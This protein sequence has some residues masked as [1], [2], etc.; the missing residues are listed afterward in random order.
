MISVEKEFKNIMTRLSVSLLFF[1]ILF[2]LLTGGASALGELLISLFPRS[3]A[4]YIVSDLASSLAYLIS[5][6]L[7][8]PFFYL[9]SRGGKVYPLKLELKFPEP[10]PVLSYFAIILAGLAIITPMTYVNSLLFPVSYGDMEIFGFDFSKPYML[11][12]TF[13]A[14][15]IVPAFA[16]ELLFRGL[17]VSNLRPYGKSVAV[18]VSAVA[19]GLMHQNPLQLLYATAAGIVF[20][21]V[22]VETESI[23]CCIAL[24]F[25]NN[26]ISVIQ[27]Y[28]SYIFD[29]YTAS[30]FSFFFVVLTGIL[31]IICAVFLASSMKMRSAAKRSVS[32]R[33][34]WGRYELSPSDFCEKVNFVS[35]AFK[36]PVFVIYIVA[37]AAEIVSFGALLYVSS[38]GG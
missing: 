27:A 11:V 16:E 22:Y 8:V 3:D 6:V 17:L 24:H 34:Y 26:F 29:E 5:F 25:A 21:V 9:I 20:G 23:W 4:V 38:L 2:P 32:Q 15:A 13:I 14:S 37:C 19:F 35:V 10:H 12:L 28:C 1:A 18:I 7:P 36:N 33:S 30:V 31:G